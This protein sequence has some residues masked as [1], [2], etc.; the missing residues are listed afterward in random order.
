MTL[1]I[2]TIVPLLAAAGGIMS[3]F[4]A[5]ITSQQSEAYGVANGIAAEALAAVRTVLSFNGE[6]RTVR[7]YGMSLNK[8]MQVGIKGG[9][10]NGLLI[11]FANCVFLCAYA[12]A[13]WYGGT[14]VRAGTYT[15]VMILCH[16]LPS[17]TIAFSSSEGHAD[18]SFTSFSQPQAS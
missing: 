3:V 11:G 17:S 6:D 10:L 12:L 2:C 8:P 18:K 4:L 1:V 14:R 15:G 7:R 5:R 9:A 13:L 16:P